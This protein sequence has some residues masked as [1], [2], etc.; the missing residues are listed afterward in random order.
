MP[1]ITASHPPWLLL[2]IGVGRNTLQRHHE[3]EGIKCNLWIN[4]TFPQWQWDKH[5]KVWSQL[6]G[7]FPKGYVQFD[8][9]CDLEWYENKVETIVKIHSYNLLSENCRNLSLA[10]TTK[11]KACEVVSQ[12]GS[13]RVTL[14]ALG[15]AKEC[16]GMNPHTPKWTPMLGIG[17][18]MDSRIFK[19]R[20]QGS[21]P[22]GLKSF[23]HH[24]KTIET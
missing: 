1:W 5:L 14:H 2:W 7:E 24:W 12:E 17:V 3:S 4:T 21:K 22:I 19:A 23:L 8:M 16:E 10:L 18:P 9:K 11:A 6:K 20:L 15:S 13:L